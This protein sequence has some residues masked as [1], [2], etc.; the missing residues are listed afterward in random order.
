MSICRNGC[1]QETLEPTSYSYQ[2]YSHLPILISFVEFSFLGCGMRDNNLQFYFTVMC[3]IEL[4]KCCSQSTNQEALL[5]LVEESMYNWHNFILFIWQNW[6][7][8]LLRHDTSF[9]SIL[10]SYY[11][12]FCCYYS[13]WCF[14]IWSWMVCNMVG[15]LWWPLNSQSPCFEVMRLW[16]CVNT[17]DL[18]SQDSMTS[19][20]SSNPW[21]LS[22]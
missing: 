16:S 14:A 8:N 7:V 10:V 11:H 1:F 5:S 6:P 19:P 17:P 2:V 15:S 3:L 4:Q 13:N 20:N 18:D 22:V 12:W 9:I 21:E